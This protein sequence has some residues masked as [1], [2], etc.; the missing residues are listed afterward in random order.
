MFVELGLF[1]NVIV[2][3]VDYIAMH[4]RLSYNPPCLCS[5]CLLLLTVFKALLQQFPY[6]YSL[7]IFASGFIPRPPK[8][9]PLPTGP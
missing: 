5:Y 4:L 9:H 6:K 8:M 1:T 3:V 2:F 7:Y